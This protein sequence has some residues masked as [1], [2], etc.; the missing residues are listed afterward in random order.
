MNFK[1]ILTL[2]SSL[3]LCILLIISAFDIEQR[4][5]CSLLSSY[6]QNQNF[7]AIKTFTVSLI[8]INFHS[9]S[10]HPSFRNST[11]KS[12]KSF[13]AAKKTNGILGCV[14][15]SIASRT[16]EVIIALWHWWAM[17]GVLCPVLASQERH[18]ATGKSLTKGH[19]YD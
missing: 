13:V 3:S 9:N 6:L 18:G 12:E 1:I 10:Y 16:K 11:Q 8:F 14:R 17:P 5:D 7:L 2:S 4:W 15:H 19:E